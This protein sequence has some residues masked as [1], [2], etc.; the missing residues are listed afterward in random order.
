VSN[1][2]PFQY[3]VERLIKKTAAQC[4]AVSCAVEWMR[5]P[6]LV[7]TALHCLKE[8]AAP[9]SGVCITVPDNSMVGI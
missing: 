7:D 3:L 4:E 1:H 6:A 5:P 2:P 8:K 9:K